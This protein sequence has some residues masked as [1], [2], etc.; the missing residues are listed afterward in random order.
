MSSLP[1]RHGPVRFAVGDPEGK[2]S[3]SWRVWAEGDDVYLACRDNAR[4]TKASLHGSGRWRFGFT[5]EAALARP[6]LVPPGTDRAWEVWDRPAEQV[7]GITRALDLVFVN[8]E[9]A[10]EPVDRDH[11]LWRKNVFLPPAP[12]GYAGMATV[13]YTAGPRPVPATG[14]DIWVADLAL[15]RGEHAHVVYHTE[16]DSGAGT[17]LIRREAAR[18][19]AEADRAR[20]ALPETGYLYV[21]GN[22]P[23]GSR[24]I[25]GARAPIEGRSPDA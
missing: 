20:E 12:N 8:S 16:P 4:E 11:K 25:V 19:L 17:E 13:F 9:L 14:P 18:Y 10:L 24:L 3:N 15:P 22:R 5:G 21:L 2:T 6:D 23:D 7:P 1:I